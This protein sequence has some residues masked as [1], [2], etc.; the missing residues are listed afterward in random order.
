MAPMRRITA[1]HG[2]AEML[3]LKQQDKLDLQV[4]TLLSLFNSREFFDFSVL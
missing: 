1:L 3:R 2:A 4:I